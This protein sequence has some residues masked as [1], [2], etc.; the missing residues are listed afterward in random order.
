M[1]AQAARLVAHSSKPAR[2]RAILDLIRTRPI[3][4]QEELVA[5]L[6]RRRLDV[7]QAT[8]S[9]DIRELGLLRVHENGGPR[10]VAAAAEYDLETA[11]MRLR[12]ALREHVRVIE[13]VDLFGVIHAAPGTAPLVAGAIDGARFD[14]VAGT[15]AGDDTVFVLTR[16]RPAA[17]RLLM[18]LKTMGGRDE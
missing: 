11:S 17:Q 8:V 18:R 3:R 14:E 16:S 5:Q 12:N 7:T 15:V 1:S 6:H 13:F 2:Q 9:R 10:Y 4:T